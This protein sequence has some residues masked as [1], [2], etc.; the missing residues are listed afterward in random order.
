[1]ASPQRS[2]A[3]SWLSLPGS[4][5]LTLPFMEETWS[6]VN[7]EL[8]GVRLP[9]PLSLAVWDLGLCLT[10]TGVSRPPGPVWA[11]ARAARGD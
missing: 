7:L 11:S 8:L 10:G 1:M 4:S 6:G 9:G 3:P 5:H 2:G